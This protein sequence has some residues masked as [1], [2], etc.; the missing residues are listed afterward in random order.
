MLALWLKPSLRLRNLTRFS[1]LIICGVR[2]AFHASYWAGYASLSSWW[3]TSSAAR[4][5]GSRL[6]YDGAASVD[7]VVAV[8]SFSPG[9][10]DALRLWI[11]GEGDA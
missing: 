7:M 2:L 1:S 8:G 3:R 6:R 9:C 10:S 4:A 11:G 5:V